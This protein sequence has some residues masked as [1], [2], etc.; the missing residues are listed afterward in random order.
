MA[1][2]ILDYV[3]SRRNSAKQAVT[4][5][6]QQLATAQTAVSNAATNLAAE[7]ALLVSL[8]KSA[9]DI[10]QKLATIPTPADGEA[11]LADLEQVTIRQRASQSDIVDVQRELAVAQGD[12]AVAQA[13]LARAT[14]QLNAAE[15]DL[16]LATDANKRRDDWKTALATEPLK[17]IDTAAT[18]LLAGPAFTQA[19]A[20]ITADI[21]AKLLARAEERRAAEAA[22]IESAETK[23]KAAAGAVV[24]EHIAKGGL[25][26]QATDQ[27]QAFAEIESATGEFVTSGAT[28]FAQAQALLADVATPENSPLTAEQSERINDASLKASREAAADEEKAV[29]DKRKALEAKQAILDDAI[30][31]AKADPEDA[32]KAQD[33]IDAQGEVDTAQTAFDTENDAWLDNLK[34]YEAAISDVED[35]Q[36]ALNL[37]RQNAIARKVD[38]ETDPAVMAAK[39]LLAAAEL[40]LKTAEDAYKA[41]P[42]GILHAWEAA[43]PDATWRLFEQYEQAQETLTALKNSPATSVQSTLDTAQTA[44]V[45]AQLNADAS[46]S[47]LSQLV[48]EQELRATRDAGMRQAASARLFSALRGDE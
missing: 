23:T 39:P 2:T 24:A 29:E 18:T 40:A 19:K 17:S 16:K 26:V 47:V 38:P 14:A 12:A 48:A 13:D 3:T 33:V 44:Y 9:A 30:V 35:K 32:T 21:P 15:A 8:D 22:R 27:L 4:S 10:R 31:A 43:V 20:R 5:T 37:A 42:H 6:Q 36:K 41:S 25:S 45:T 46:T 34:D 11:L 28:R 7:T 1:T